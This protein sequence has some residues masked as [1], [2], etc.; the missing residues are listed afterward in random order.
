M[1]REEND[2][3]DRQGL[4]Q[5][6]VKHL[7]MHCSPMTTIGRVIKRGLTTVRNT[8]VRVLGVVLVIIAGLYIA[9]FR[10][11]FALVPSLSAH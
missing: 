9:G 6:L 8:F 7:Y 3:L 5:S 2:K 10:S 4:H 11:G 1:R